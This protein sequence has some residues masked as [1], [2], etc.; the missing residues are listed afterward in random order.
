MAKTK[1]RR[2]RMPGYAA[3]VI[4]PTPERAQHDPVERIGKQILDAD[5][6]I[7][8]PF[9]TVDVLAIML[10]R[11][12]ITALMEKA[13]RQFRDDFDLG[14][15]YG[16]RAAQLVRIGSGSSGDAMA[17]SQ[18][19][20]RD[21]VHDAM[22]IAGGRTSP[23]GSCMWHILGEGMHVEEWAKAEGWKG[24]PLMRE[25]ASGILIAALGMLVVHYGLDHQA[26]PK[27]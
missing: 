5:G 18:Q 23:A 11:G 24:R 15:L 3:D 19:S 14:C 17:V 7:G 6:N 1:A 21:R 13:G 20:A 22:A 16:I 25:T 10:R 27:Y 8:N 9:R 26:G 4:A 12:T 2:K